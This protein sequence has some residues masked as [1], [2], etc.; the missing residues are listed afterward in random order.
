ML[1]ERDLPAAQEIPRQVGN[2][3]RCA[4]AVG[5]RH[6][7]RLVEVAVVNPTLP[8]NADQSPAH[9]AAGSRRVEAGRQEIHVAVIGALGLQ[10]LSEP[11]DRALVMVNSL[12][13]TMP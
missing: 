1:G 11:P 13:N 5:Y 8:V 4:V 9:D 6:A 10:L 12:L 7:E 3:Q 2:R